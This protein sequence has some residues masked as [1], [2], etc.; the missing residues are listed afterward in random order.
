M[1]LCGSLCVVMCNGVRADTSGVLELKAVLW[2]GNLRLSKFNI[3]K[4]NNNSD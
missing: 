4:S 1:T 3:S 2:V